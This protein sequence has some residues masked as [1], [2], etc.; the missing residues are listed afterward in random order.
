MDEKPIREF[1]AEMLEDNCLEWHFTMLG[2]CDSPYEQGVYHGKIFVPANYPFSPPDVVLLTP[3][4]RFELDKRICL[5]ISSY[6]P[7]NW[8]PTYGIATVLHALREFMSTPGNNGIGAI[9]YPK[10]VREELALKS[11]TYKCAVCGCDAA[12]VYARLIALPPTTEA[13]KVDN[14]DALATPKMGPSSPS[15]GSPQ[16]TNESTSRSPLELQRLPSS[17]PLPGASEAPPSEMAGTPLQPRRLLEGDDALPPAT[18][19]NNATPVDQ[20]APVAELPQPA[21]ATPVVRPV[22]PPPVAVRRVEARNGEIIVNLSI[23]QIDRLIHFFLCVVLAVLS[24]K[25]L[26]AYWDQLL[27]IL[28]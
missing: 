13:D 8:H 11:R 1:C 21:P 2:P 24:K 3:N 28:W 25:A 22:P 9:E 14:L 12:E 18:L 6:H 19:P 23:G 4:G 20:P 15:M 7:E 10:A 16:N 26:Q 27:E 17:V 5:S